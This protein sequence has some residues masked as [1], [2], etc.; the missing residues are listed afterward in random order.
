MISDFSK[1]FCKTINNP[2]KNIF[3]IC[4]LSTD[5]WGVIEELLWQ[6]SKESKNSYVG[7]GHVGIKQILLQVQQIWTAY[8]VT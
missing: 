4:F 3:K 8:L 6:N 1:L 7:K 2:E 5:R